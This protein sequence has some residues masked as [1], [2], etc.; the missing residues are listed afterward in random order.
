[1]TT[2]QCIGLRIENLIRAEYVTICPFIPARVWRYY[3]TCCPCSESRC[4][5]GGEAT[6]FLRFRPGPGARPA[7]SLDVGSIPNDSVKK[8]WMNTDKHEFKAPKSAEA[9][10]RNVSPIVQTISTGKNR[11]NFHSYSCL[12][13]FIRGCFESFRI[14]RKRGRRNKG[15]SAPCGGPIL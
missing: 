8:P 14:N 10:L 3:E 15:H 6:F 4:H 5:A 1:M 13:V 7:K 11:S 9:G 2:L 12:F